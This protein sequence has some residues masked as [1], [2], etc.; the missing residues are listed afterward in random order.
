MREIAL[1]GNRFYKLATE[2]LSKGGSFSFRGH[3]GSMYPFI[4]DGAILTVEPVQAHRLRVGDVV[5]YRSQAR[6]VVHRV[7]AK[8]MLD[9]QADLWIRGDAFAGSGEKLSA[10]S[11]IGRV[12][13][14]KQRSRIIP[15]NSFFWRWLGIVWVKLAP[16]GQGVIWAASTVLRI[17]KK[18]LLRA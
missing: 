9:S 11:V 13:N 18:I 1:N 6:V 2:I 14:V 7:I 8:R 3:G 5:L 15:L 17:S 12:V 10:A 4:R 16:L